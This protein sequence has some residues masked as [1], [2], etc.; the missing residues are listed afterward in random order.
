LKLLKVSEA[1]ITLVE[2]PIVEEKTDE[3]AKEEVSAE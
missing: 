1:G 3:P 2:L